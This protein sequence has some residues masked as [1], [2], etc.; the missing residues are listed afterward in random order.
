MKLFLDTTNEIVLGLLDS[1]NEWVE[2][3][4]YEGLKGSAVIHRLIFD[5][6]EK[7]KTE[8][9]DIEC[10]IQISGPGSY[11]GMRVSDGISQIFSWQDFK[12][13]S[14]YHFDIPLILDYQKG[15]WYTEAFKGELFLYKWNG[16]ESE[17]TLLKIIEAR[18]ILEASDIPVFCLNSKSSAQAESIS[19]RELIYKNSKKIF[20]YIIDN[21]MKQEL[22]YFRALEDEFSKAKQ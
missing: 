11:T 22:F 9:K 15:Y 16:L 7:Y 17:K 10:L 12:V 3:Q 19:T 6:L 1:N 13:Y 2:Y 8:I 14:A 21:K 18:E 5:N 4:V 20:N